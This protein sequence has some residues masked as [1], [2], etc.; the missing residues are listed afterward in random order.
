MWV[1]LGFLY[2]IMCF[3]VFKGLKPLSLI[4]RTSLLN[5]MDTDCFWV[6]V[7][8]EVHGLSAEQQQ[9]AFIKV[10]L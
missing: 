2:L 10:S 1:K 5:H 6:A 3:P 7:V 4:D 8:Q 9:P